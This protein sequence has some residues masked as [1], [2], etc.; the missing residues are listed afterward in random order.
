[1][2]L[3]PHSYSLG[4]HEAICYLFSVAAGLQSMVLGENQILRQVKDAYRI[5]T[6]A[7]RTATVLNRLFHKALEVGKRVRSDTAI[8]KGA[9]TVSAAAVGLAAKQFDNSGPLT[10]LVVGAGETGEQ[11]LKAFSDW[12]CHNLLVANRTN[13]RARKV[14][15]KYGAQA[16]EYEGWERLLGTCDIAITSVSVSAPIVT[17]DSGGEILRER[18]NDPLLLIDLS[19]PRAIDEKVGE[20]ENVLLHTID[21]LQEVVDSTFERRAEEILKAE[22]IVTQAVNEFTCWLHSLQLA[23]TIS[24]LK[25]R[26]ESI[27]DGELHKLKNRLSE[28]EY[29]KVQEYARFINGKY[30]GLII[31]NLKSLSSDGRHLESIEILRSLF[32]TEIG[33]ME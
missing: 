17:P 7:G 3:A 32:E 1:M 18:R 24:F 12:G 6:Q 19:V 8:N 29:E 15:E 23:P 28:S 26:F 9:A 2:D 20:I 16:V 25:N 27:S 31:K 33:G 14:A 4:H 21:D 13:S 22:E 5:S 30:L 11:V 10:I